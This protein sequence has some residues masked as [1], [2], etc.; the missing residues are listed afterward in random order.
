MM[1]YK[2]TFRPSKKILLSFAGILLILSLT[3]CQPADEPSSSVE[4]SST[5]V[6]P[7]ESTD[8]PTAEN[9]TPDANDPGNTSA[10]SDQSASTASSAD[11]DSESAEASSE[12][13]EAQ[14]PYYFDDFELTALNGDTKSLYDYE[15]Q[16]IILNFWA[17]WC[18]YCEQEMPLLNEVHQRDG[19][20]VVA[21]DV[22]EDA[23]TVQ[24]YIDLYG[25][26]LDFYLDEDSA[27]ASMF[28]V[29]AF[30]TTIFIGPDFEYYYSYPGMLTDDYLSQ[31][32]DAIDT[33]QATK[34]EGQ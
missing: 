33:Y 25:Y 19:I 1:N 29:S 22:G 21:I 7:T 30:P 16:L 26:D 13:A 11:S 34:N 28:G 12:T 18:T 10:Q 3:A 23:Q 6:N 31:L 2:N 27:L 20:K 32:L 8:A 5:A 4:P 17:T 14:E 24:D 9:N 15:G